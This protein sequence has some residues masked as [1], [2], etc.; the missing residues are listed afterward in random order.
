MREGLAA[1][2]G[3]PV[4]CVVGVPAATATTL[5]PRDAAMPF[6][7]IGPRRIR[8]AS[9]ARDRRRPPSTCARRTPGADRAREFHPGVL[10]PRRT[11]GE[12]LQGYTLVPDLSAKCS[13]SKPCWRSRSRFGPRWIQS[14]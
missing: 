2:A 6:R 10:K 1:P 3:T 5:L 8:L 12:G 9:K 4:A 13:L 14:E 11:T 7:I